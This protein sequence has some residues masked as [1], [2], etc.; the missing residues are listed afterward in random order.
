MVIDIS[1]RYKVPIINATRT[2]HGKLKF[3]CQHCFQWHYH[4]LGNGHR[5]AHCVKPNGPFK[6]GYILHEID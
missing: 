5:L 3:Y 2:K 1:N 4:G 6:R